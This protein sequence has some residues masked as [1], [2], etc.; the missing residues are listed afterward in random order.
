MKFVDLYAGLG[1]FHVGL[2]Q[3]GNE[4]VYA[5]EINTE[6]NEIYQ[7]NHLLKL[8]VKVEKNWRKN[9]WIMKKLGY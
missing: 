5:S 6:L 3:E 9:F 4:C 2:A 1:G 8:K 7:S